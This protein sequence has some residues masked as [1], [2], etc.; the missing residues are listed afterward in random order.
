MSYVD[1]FE[2]NKVKKK[3]KDAYLRE[4]KVPFLNTDEKKNKKTEDIKN[5]S[6]TLIKEGKV[7]LLVMWGDMHL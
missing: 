7:L 5:K 3:K 2:D 6:R 4:L 1:V